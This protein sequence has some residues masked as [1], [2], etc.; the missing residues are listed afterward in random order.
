MWKAGIDIKKS[1]DGY[2]KSL[3]SEEIETLRWPYWEVNNLELTT[4]EE[5]KV[6]YV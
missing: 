4:A 6:I 1:V 3:E 5:G 2:L